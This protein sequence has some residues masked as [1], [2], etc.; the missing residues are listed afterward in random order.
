M[1][2]PPNKKMLD[3]KKQVQELFLMKAQLNLNIAQLK[4]DMTIEALNE[5]D[6]KTGLPLTKDTSEL[7]IKPM[8]YFNDND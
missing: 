7:E 3:M 4:I 2:K 6:E 1:V 5:A 8:P